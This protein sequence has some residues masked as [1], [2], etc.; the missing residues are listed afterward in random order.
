M[1]E[2]GRCLKLR[3]SEPTDLWIKPLSRNPDPL[4]SFGRSARRSAR[5]KGESHCSAHMSRCS[6]H[7][8][9]HELCC[10]T[11]RVCCSTSSGRTARR[12]GR[13]ARQSVAE[14]MNSSA[15]VESN[16]AWGIV[17]GGGSARGRRAATAADGIK[18]PTP[19]P[20][21]VSPKDG[22]EDIVVLASGSWIL[23]F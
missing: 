20:L 18:V 7:T 2:A 3:N 9:A 14:K 16:G 5:R 23:G 12:I 15:L 21:S 22:A 19:P 6:S 1:V 8:S 13:V 11:M 10:S 17:D 4:K